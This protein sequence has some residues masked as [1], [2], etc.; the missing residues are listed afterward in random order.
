[1]KNQKTFRDITE[2][3]SKKSIY[4]LFATSK[5]KSTNDKRKIYSFSLDT[6]KHTRF[7]NKNKKLNLIEWKKKENFSGFFHLPKHLL[8]FC[9]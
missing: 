6:H 1:M 4:I 3:N 7:Q 5:K 2:L 9:L 8:L